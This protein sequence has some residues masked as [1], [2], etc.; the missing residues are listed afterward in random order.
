LFFSSFRNHLSN[1]HQKPEYKCTE[2]KK[3]TSVAGKNMKI[4]DRI[5]RNL[6]LKI[7]RIGNLHLKVVLV[8]NMLKTVVRKAN[9][10]IKQLNIIIVIVQDRV[11]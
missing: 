10:I 1:H 3:F 4:I 8:Q 11:S 7:L 6:L 5:M 9:P 2:E